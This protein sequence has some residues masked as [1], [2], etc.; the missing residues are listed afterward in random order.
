MNLSAQ[1]KIEI[2]NRDGQVTRNYKL[3]PYSKFEMFED[4]LK[5]EMRIKKF[6]YVLEEESF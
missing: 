6:I 4:Y 1:V 5:S 3:V 2:S